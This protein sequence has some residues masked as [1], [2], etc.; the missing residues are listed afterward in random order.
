M[1]DTVVIPLLGEHAMAFDGRLGMIARDEAAGTTARRLAL[2]GVVLLAVAAREPAV[3]QTPAYQVYQYDSLGNLIR[4]WGND[5]NRAEF[6]Y[7]PADNRTSTAVVQGSA[8]PAPEPPVPLPTP[9]Y[10]M[11]PRPGA[12]PLVAPY[13][14]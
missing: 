2:L 14:P 11:L 9:R 7:D 5:G 12:A 1:A 3:A 10:Y 6:S 8:P 4:S 13:T